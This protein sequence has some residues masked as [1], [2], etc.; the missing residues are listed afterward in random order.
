M[1]SGATKQHKGLLRISNPA[2]N[3]FDTDMLGGGEQAVHEMLARGGHNR[4]SETKQNYIID[5]VL[6][7]ASQ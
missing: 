6:H 1:G 3:Q 7:A 4:T 5:V 2:C